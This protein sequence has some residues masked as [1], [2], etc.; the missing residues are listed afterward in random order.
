MFVGF[1]FWFV[2]RVD[3]AMTIEA[4]TLLVTPH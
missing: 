1:L 2:L 4:K 3:M